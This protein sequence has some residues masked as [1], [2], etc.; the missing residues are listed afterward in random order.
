MEY[1][2]KSLE[3]TER[4]A[5]EIAE[6]INFNADKA[7]VVGLYGDLGA[8]KTTFMKYFAKHFGVEEEVQ[9]PTFIIMRIFEMNQS[10]VASRKSQAT[11]LIHIDAYRI[12]KAEE[13]LNLGWKE[14]LAHPSNL[15]CMEWPEKVAEILP[16]HIMLRFEHVEDPE[17]SE[18]QNNTRKISL[19]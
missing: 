16:E 15:I 4:I 2:S 6:K 18:G 17:Q 5:G 8:G 9:S 11:K 3:D 7:T 12:E 14:L 10:Q 19:A 13:L 1:I